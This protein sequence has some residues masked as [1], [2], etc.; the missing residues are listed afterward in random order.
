M[1]TIGFLGLGAMGLP[2]AKRLCAAGHRLN[3]AVHSNPAPA[4][5]L[6]ALGARLVG[7]PAEVVA[8]AD[9]VVSIL[10]ADA[11]VREVL[12]APAVI[13]AMAPGA[14]ILEMSS[15]RADTVRDLAD[16][17]RERNVAVLDAPVSGGVPGA[18]AGALTIMCGGDADVLEKSRPVLAVMGGKIRLVGGI[19]DAKNLKSVNNLLGAAN[20]V[21]VAEALTLS[22]K[23][24]LDLEA[25]YDVISSSSGQSFNFDNRFKRMADEKFEGG[26]KT[27]LM[28]KDMRIA[29]SQA[30]GLSMPLATLAYQ[31]YQLTDPARRDLDYSA[32]SRVL[33]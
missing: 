29:L 17:Y 8:G 20:A 1:S 5:E 26:F 10:P 28:M 9:F 3:I 18:V 7:G 2:M 4:R 14:V 6:E 25:V 22:R 16:A 32:V 23:M 19:G 21:L 33:E 11:E 24:G 30:D 27:S 12:L 31:I 15:T 13:D